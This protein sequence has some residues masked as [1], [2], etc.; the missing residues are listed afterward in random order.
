MWLFTRGYLKYGPQQSGFRST[1]PQSATHVLARSWAAAGWRARPSQNFCG[2]FNGLVSV[3]QK[4]YRRLGFFWKPPWDMKW[5]DDFLQ[6]FPQTNSNEKCYRKLTPYLS[7]K[8]HVSCRFTL[9]NHARSKATKIEI[10]Q[11]TCGFWHVWQLDMKQLLEFADQHVR[12]IPNEIPSFAWV[13][14]WVVE[15]LSG[16]GTV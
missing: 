4:I 2:K 1:E 9:K 8:K 14:P 12:N 7:R 15:V 5:Y 16:W 6:I 10:C 13:F 3:Q 11:Q